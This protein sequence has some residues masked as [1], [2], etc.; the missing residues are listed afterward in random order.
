MTAPDDERELLAAD[1][2]RVRVHRGRAQA[3]GFDRH[4]AR[5]AATAAAALGSHP[6]AS[7]ELSSFLAQAPA[8]I[9]SYGTG[10]PRLELWRDPTGEPTFSLALRPLP[11]LHDTIELRTTGE[12][13]LPRATRKGP[14]LNTLLALNRELGAEALLLDG[15]G[16][17]LEGATTSIVWWLPGSHVPHTVAA[18]LRVP[19]VTEALLGNA[20]AQWDSAGARSADASPEALLDAE[21]WAVNALH[22][23]RTVTTL[24]GQALVAPAEE[25]L[26]WFRDALDHT[27]TNVT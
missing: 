21:V 11:T 10:F 4:V 19:S 25:R 8:H 23:I 1:S 17:V 14:N 20:A 26:A 13:L 22:G 12:L 18:P 24:D 2:F 27:W 15:T 9:A 6:G 5:F 3:R 16:H 7:A